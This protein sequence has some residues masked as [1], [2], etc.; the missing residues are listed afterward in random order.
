VLAFGP[1]S[2]SR[3]FVSGLWNK[4]DAILAL[5]YDQGV[6]PFKMISVN[7]FAYYWAGLPAVCAA[8]LHGPAFDIAN[9]NAASPDAL[10]KAIFLALDILKNRQS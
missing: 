3:M 10:R 4:Y 6:L 2:A 5:T 7:G 1:F 9:T 8:P